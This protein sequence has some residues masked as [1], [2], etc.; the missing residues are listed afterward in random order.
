MD[1]LLLLDEVNRANVPKVLGDL[2]LTLEPS[3]RQKWNGTGWRGGVAVTLPYSARQFE[4]PDNIYV[5][6]TMNTSDRSIAPLDAALRRRFAFVRVLPLGDQDLD[7]ALRSV[8]GDAIV[9]LAQ[10]SVQMLGL[11]NTRVLNPVLGPDGKL[12]T[13]IFL[14]LSLWAWATW[15]FRLNSCALWERS[16]ALLGRRRGQQTAEART[17]STWQKRAPVAEAGVSSCSTRCTR[18]RMSRQSPTRTVAVM[19]TLR[20][21]MTE[22]ATPRHQASQLGGGQKPIPCCTCQAI[23]HSE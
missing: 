16:N 4:V 18:R 2:L 6:G 9:D 17:S 13:A 5:L 21:G 10:D 12:G 14:I 19:M 20:S 15:S 3:K 1:Y 11:L 7:L 23:A 22:L 8:R